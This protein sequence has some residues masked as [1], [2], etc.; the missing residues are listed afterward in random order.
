L[1]HAGC[2]E[3]DDTSCQELGDRYETG[4]GVTANLPLARH[5]Y[6]TFS[7]YAVERERMDDLDRALPRDP[8]RAEKALERA[9]KGGKQASCV[10]LAVILERGAGVTRDRARAAKLYAAACDKNERA[11][12]TRGGRLARHTGDLA[13]AVAAWKKGCAD[14]GGDARACVLL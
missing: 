13:G 8:A 7:G 4:D 9:C 11:G 1:L 10:T 6:Q 12:C 5:Y 3:L 2:H 14:G